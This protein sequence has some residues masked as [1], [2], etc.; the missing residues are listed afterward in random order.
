MILH[1]NLERVGEDMRV[2]M[3]DSLRDICK[4]KDNILEGFLNKHKVIQSKMKVT[5]REEVIKRM[6]KGIAPKYDENIIQNIQQESI[7]SR[8]NLNDM[9]NFSINIDRSAPKTNRKRSYLNVG[10][11]QNQKVSYNQFIQ[12]PNIV[13][14]E[15]Q[16]LQRIKQQTHDNLKLPVNHKFRKHRSELSTIVSSEHSSSL[17]I[18]KGTKLN[19]RDSSLVSTNSQPPNFV[20]IKLNTITH[21]VKPSQ[22]QL[23]MKKLC[24]SDLGIDVE[25]NEVIM[26]NG[27]EANSEADN[28]QKTI[29]LKNLKVLQLMMA[30][31]VHNDNPN[32]KKEKLNLNKYINTSI[33]NWSKVK[34]KPN[35]D[36]DTGFFEIP[37]VSKLN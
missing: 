24:N 4:E 17:N 11:V 19:S 34:N 6:V 27:E 21:S 36:Y 3:I 30:K 31:I 5:F 22:F 18:H 35:A 16:G 15:L 12:T 28:K 23:N 14:S 37:L 32:I 9:K 10:D 26:V 25:N 33:R 2:K 8:Q 29:K 7:S 20:N 13:Q 1:I